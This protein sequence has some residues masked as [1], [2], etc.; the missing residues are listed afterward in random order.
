MSLLAET[1]WWPSGTPGD[2]ETAVQIMVKTHQPC[3]V[4]GHK[5]FYGSAVLGTPESVGTNGRID[6]QVQQISHLVCSLAG[7]RC[8]EAWGTFSTWTN[9]SITALIAWRR[10][11]EKGIGRHSTLQ[12]REWSVFNQANIGT[13]SRATL[14]RL[15][16]DGTERVWA[17]PSS[18]ML[19][20]AETETR[21]SGLNIGS[22]VATLLDAGRFWMSARTG[23]QFGWDSEFDLRLQSQWMWQHVQ[24]SS[25]ICSW[26]IVIVTGTL[27]SQ[28]NKP[29]LSD[30]ALIALMSV[31]VDVRYEIAH[32]GSVA[33][34]VVCRP[35]CVYVCVCGEG[36]LVGSVSLL[37]YTTTKCFAGWLPW[38]SIGAP[39]D[40]ETAVQIPA[41]SSMGYSSGYPAGRLAFW[42]QR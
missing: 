20:W 28:Q 16:R 18:T 23:W 15:L 19:S 24:M 13:V 6:W 9:Q 35:L 37:S 11:V 1:P 34:R 33:S 10:G 41:E 7:Q 38:W 29:S 5:G 27:N 8:S 42:D 17:F 32:D 26:D 12:D 39:P 21:I 22:L 30:H 31:V 2:L 3:T 40:R 25:Q 14:G 36:Y 4:C